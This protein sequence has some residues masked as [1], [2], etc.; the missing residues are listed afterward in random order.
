MKPPDQGPNW[1]RQADGTILYRQSRSE[2]T[3]Q[4]SDRQLQQVH[5]LV[6]SEFDFV[7]LT[8]IPVVA[9]TIMWRQGLVGGLVV[10][11]SLA[12]WLTA[13]QIFHLRI[14]RKK[15]STVEGS[16]RAEEILDISLSRAVRSALGKYSNR[17][18]WGSAI[19]FSGFVLR[20]FD[21]S[22]TD[23]S[24]IVALLGTCQPAGCGFYDRSIRSSRDPIR[25]GNT[26]ATIGC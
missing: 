14:K 26:E 24:R 17:N 16:L 20:L 19:L 7:F 3:L 22:R 11:L 13:N 2:T 6:R 15:A 4:I 12:A 8:L 21:V 25:E 1:Q 9:R 18:L 23:L 5:N 10:A